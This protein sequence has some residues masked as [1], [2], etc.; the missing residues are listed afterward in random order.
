MKHILA[1]LILTAALFSCSETKK[2]APVEQT[3]EIITDQ[4]TVPSETK[5]SGATAAKQSE[6]IDDVFAIKS[7]QFE[8]T[9]S[10]IQKRDPFKPYDGEVSTEIGGPELTPLERYDVSQLILTAVIWGI[11]EPRA[12]VRAPDGQD[13]IVKKDMRIGRNSG[14]ISRIAKKELVVA[15]EYRDPLGK[16]VVKE[17]TLFLGGKEGLD[18]AMDE[19]E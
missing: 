6:A 17:S 2:T 19:L 4:K 14:K 10:P 3:P 8:Y 18:K 5:P 7:K 1:V 12:L 9:Y 13:Y 11:S 15:E 16:L